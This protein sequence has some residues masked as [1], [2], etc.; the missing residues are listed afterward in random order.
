MATLA[1]DGRRLNLLSLEAL[2]DPGGGTQYR[3]DA[4]LIRDTYGPGSGSIV[5][6]AEF[7]KM[8]NGDRLNFNY[9]F[10]FEW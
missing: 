6:E 7:N 8:L 2:A 9:W 3:F 10:G 5:S 4:Q 1:A